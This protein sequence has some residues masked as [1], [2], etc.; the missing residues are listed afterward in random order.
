MDYELMHKKA[1]H[2]GG[3]IRN[4]IR[5]V[6]GLSP[7]VVFRCSQVFISC[8]EIYLNRTCEKLF[9][10]AGSFHNAIYSCDGAGHYNEIAGTKCFMGACCSNLVYSGSEIQ[11]VPA[12]ASLG[13]LKSENRLETGLRTVTACPFSVDS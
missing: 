12:C 8:I 11:P 1:P 13:N 5:H 9:S 7:S 3:A 4:L 10:N 2:K 6:F